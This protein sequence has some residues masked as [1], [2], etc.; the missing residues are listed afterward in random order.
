MMTE[1]K[2]NFNLKK[3]ERM[4]HPPRWILKSRPTSTINRQ[5]LEPER[6]DVALRHE[7]GEVGDEGRN[8]RVHPALSVDFFQQ[9]TSHQTSP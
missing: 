8:G 2:A 1:K 9:P 6:E 5:E 7:T 3:T 4:A